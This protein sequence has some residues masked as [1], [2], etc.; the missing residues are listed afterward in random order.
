MSVFIPFQNSAIP[1]HPTR[2]TNCHCL[3][4][5][6]GRLST[7]GN[8]MNPHTITYYKQSGPVL[9]RSTEDWRWPMCLLPWPVLC[10]CLVLLIHVAPYNLLDS[11]AFNNELQRKWLG[12][13]WGTLLWL[14]KTKEDL[15]QDSRF[16]GW[17]CVWGLYNIQLPTQR[18]SVSEQ[19]RSF[20][21]LHTFH[22]ECTEKVR[23]L[24]HLPGPL[25]QQCLPW[26]VVIT[27]LFTGASP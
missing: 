15:H 11:T 12:L 2:D 27:S 17:D 25:W 3:S 20:H 26:P 13:I 14:S 5:T 10:P 22:T 23:N 18:S 19:H 6:V 1:K 21:V 4:L 16:L 8:C 9:L 24:L 7:N